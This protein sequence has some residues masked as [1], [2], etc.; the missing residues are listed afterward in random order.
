M[1]IQRTHTHT[2]HDYTAKPRWT[3]FLTAAADAIRSFVRH[4][5]FNDIGVTLSRKLVYIVKGGWVFRGGMERVDTV[6]TEWTKR[7]FSA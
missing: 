5:R 7:S 2:T 3:K 4:F 6:D 1:I